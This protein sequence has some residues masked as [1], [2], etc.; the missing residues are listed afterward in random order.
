MSNKDAPAY[1]VPVAATPM[2]DILPCFD[3][4]ITKFEYFYAAALQGLCANPGYTMTPE[5]FAE[6]A[7]DI[8]EAALAELERR[9]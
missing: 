8:T 4:G 6:R 7:A 3:W 1:P 9:G 2:G 5:Q